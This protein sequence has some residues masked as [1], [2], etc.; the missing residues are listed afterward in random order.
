MMTVFAGPWSGVINQTFA[1]CTKTG[2]PFFHWLIGHIVLPVY[3]HYPAMISGRVTPS[4]IRNW[5]TPHCFSIVDFCNMNTICFYTY[6]RVNWTALFM[7]TS[8]LSCVCRCSRILRSTIKFL[9]VS[10]DVW[11]PS[12]YVVTT[13]RT[14]SF[15]CTLCIWILLC[16][17]VDKL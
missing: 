12:P 14:F 2:T 1:A 11:L 5:I 16:C 9:I 8:A 7:R 4:A 15:E 6:Y 10:L 13:F 17:P 3:S